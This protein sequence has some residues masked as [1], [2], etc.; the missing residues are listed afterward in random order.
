MLSRSDE[1][2]D[3]RLAAGERLHA[4]HHGSFGPDRISQLVY[5][6]ANQ[7]TQLK[8]AVGT[9][10]AATERTLT[11]SNNG[12][13]ATL[14]DGD[15]NLTTFEYDG[16]DRPSKTRFPV[17]T[18][19]ANASSTTDFEQLS[20]DANSNVTSRRLRDGQSMSF[21][22]DNLDRLTVKGPPSPD[23]TVTFDYDNLGRLTSAAKSAIGISLSFTYDALGR[24]LTE[25]GPQGSASSEYDL[26]GRRTKLTYPGTGLFV[27]TDYLVTGETTKI[28]ENGA[29]SGVG[30]LASYGYDN[31]GNRTSVTFGN[32]AMQ[33]SAY[34]AVSRLASL[35][36][37]LAGTSNDLTVTIA[38]YNPAGQ[39][40]GVTRSNNAYAFTGYANGTTTTT[41]NG[42]NQQTNVG[43]SAVSWT[44]AAT[45]LSIRSAARATPTGR[46]PTSCGR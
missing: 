14:K 12:Q 37:D 39:I 33:A 35:T 8:V 13:V 19:G 36:N 22:Y 30:V 11:Y 6:A 38:G 20:Y 15:N 31:L 43:G 10:D 18:K 3:L 24:N 1:P 26:A 9:S 28:R 21:T 23:P 41:T 42:L 45:S 25:T 40:T 27:N 17:T 44:R 5:D 7:V 46:R 32:G 2:G 4:R 16:F 29:T 34:D